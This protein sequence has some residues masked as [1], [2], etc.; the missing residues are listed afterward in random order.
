MELE[1]RAEMNYENYAKTINIEAKTMV[2]MVRRMY[3]PAVIRYATELA[4]S[5]NTVRGAAPLANCSVQEKLLTDVS[6]LLAQMDL[7]KEKVR[8][9]RLEAVAITG[10]KEKAECYRKHVVPAME[11]LRIPVDKLETIVD[12]KFWP[13]PTYGD[14]VFEV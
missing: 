1:A 12:K 14:L 5:I 13:V 6:E 8:E 3:I 2:D 10:A 7:A 9:A 11:A 4:T